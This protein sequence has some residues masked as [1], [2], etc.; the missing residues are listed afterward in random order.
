ME[1]EQ[2]VGC[3]SDAVGGVLGADSGGVGE[4]EIGLV[5]FLDFIAGWA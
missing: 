3:W 4:Q 2:G 1:V 5:F